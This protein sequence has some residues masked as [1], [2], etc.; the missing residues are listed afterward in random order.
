MAASMAMSV[1]GLLAIGPPAGRAGSLELR[2]APLLSR[3]P[4]GPCPQILTLIETPQPYREGSY[5]LSG[6]APLAAIATGWRLTSRDGVSATWLGQL[7]GPYQRCT[8]TAG[9]ARSDDAPFRDHSY[10]RL[11]LR[12]AQAQ[13]ILDMTGLRDPN[14]FTPVI[15]EAGIRQGVPA[16]SWG[17]SD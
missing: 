4:G 10:L 3:T 2:V 17:G 1:T 7:R 12:G 13:L 14:G 5:G 16:W 15:L 9:I 11:R 6:R 8:A